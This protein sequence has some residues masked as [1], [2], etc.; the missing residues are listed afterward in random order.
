MNYNRILVIQA[1]FLTTCMS[2]TPA[3]KSVL[4][5]TWIEQ[6]PKD[7]RCIFLFDR[8]APTRD[9]RDVEQLKIVMQALIDREEATTRPLYILTEST[10]NEIRWHTRDVLCSL[11]SEITHL[12]I[13]EEKEFT[14]TSIENIDVRKLSKAVNY[15]LCLDNTTSYDENASLNYRFNNDVYEWRQG[16]LSFNDLLTEFNEQQKFA[17]TTTN[18]LLE[19]CDTIQE[20]KDVENFYKKTIEETNGHFAK[21]L[22]FIKNQEIEVSS[23]TSIYQETYNWGKSLKKNL[24]IVLIETFSPFFDLYVFSRIFIIHKQNSSLDIVVIAGCYH[25]WNISAE[26][27]GTLQGVDVYSKT[28]ELHE[29]E[30]LP[31]EVLYNVLQ[32]KTPLEE[33]PKWN[34]VLF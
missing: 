3:I 25:C 26:V 8:H 5:N 12:Q 10:L 13:M 21:Y 11:K 14:H 9:Q 34:C 19:L 29:I 33:T 16:S 6:L 17:L 30:C 28:T 27:V 31:P 2:F 32:E 23:P 18:S 15:I 7:N 1:V 4:I 20:K 24:H 22:K